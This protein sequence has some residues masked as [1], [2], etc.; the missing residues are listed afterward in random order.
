[1]SNWQPKNSGSPGILATLTDIDEATWSSPT[2]LLAFEA[3][4]DFDNSWDV[5]GR[6]LNPDRV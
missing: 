1:M 2:E 4:R 5:T 3:K 6:G